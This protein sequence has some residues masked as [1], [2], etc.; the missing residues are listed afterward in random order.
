[1]CGNRGNTLV[2]G[3][4]FI[5]RARIGGAS[6]AF[7][8]P[9]IG[10]HRAGADAGFEGLTIG[11]I[12][13]IVATGEV[14]N[15]C[16]LERGECFGPTFVC[17]VFEIGKGGIGVAFAL[18]SPGIEQ[19]QRQRRERTFCRFANLDT[20]LRIIVLVECIDGER[21]SRRAVVRLHHD[22][23]AR[24]FHGIVEIARDGGIE[25]RLVEQIA[26]VRIAGEALTVKPRR[27]GQIVLAGRQARGEIGAVGG[28]E[29]LW[30]SR[31]GSAQIG[32]RRERNG[33]KQA[34]KKNG[35]PIV[36]RISPFTCSDSSDR[37]RL[38]A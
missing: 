12:R 2:R 9:A 11:G 16:V 28:G 20:R 26:I 30:S 31:A 13:F 21:Q 38:R 37:R 7:E 32:A 25:K 22:D 24:E 18:L 1:M 4:F 8:K 27:V 19:H 35:E 33:Q 5:K 34:G 23:A 36:Q 3:Q 29:R 15:Q 10:L 14:E 6:R 17:H